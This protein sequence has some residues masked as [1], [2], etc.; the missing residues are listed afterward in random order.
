MEVI[1]QIHLLTVIRP[2]VFFLLFWKKPN[3]DFL[4]FSDDVVGTL[5]VLDELFVSH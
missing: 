4:P 1:K 2:M 3:F 5:D